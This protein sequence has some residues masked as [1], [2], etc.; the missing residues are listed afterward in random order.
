MCVKGAKTGKFEPAGCGTVRSGRF[1]GWEEWC[2]GSVVV[3][4]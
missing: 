4:A 3:G 1:G 2:K